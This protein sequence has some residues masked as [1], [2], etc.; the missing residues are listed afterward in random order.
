MRFLILSSLILAAGWTAWG[1]GAEITGRVT[2]PSGSV[3]PAAAVTV[4]NVAT[5]V[6]YPAKT[7][8][9]GYYSVPNLAP[10]NYQVDVKAAGFKPVVRAGIALQV[11]QVARVDFT[12]QLG[13]VSEQVE[14]SGAAPLVESET[15]DVGQVINNKSIVEMP[16]DGRNAWDLSK[17]TGAATYVGN[18]GDANEIPWVSLAGSRVKSQE[19]FLDGG[20]VQKS[21]LATAQAEL[22]PM[23]DAVE[24]FKVVTNNYAA[25]YGR[26]AAGIFVAVTKSGTNQFSGDAFEFLRNNALDARNFFALANPPLH[27]NQFGGTLGGPIRKNKTFFFVALETTLTGTGQPEILTLPTAAEKAG[28]FSGLR[29]A[30]GQMIPIYNPLTTAVNSTNPSQSTRDPFP[31][32]VI[33]ASMFDPVSAKAQSYYP[34]PNVPGTITG[35]NNFNTNLTEQRTQYHGTVKVDHNLSEKDRIFG[36][37]V[38]QHNFIPEADVFPTAAASGVGPAT[39]TIT[40]LAQTWMGSWIHTFSPTLLND[41][42]VGGTDQYR[43]ITNS[44]IGGNWPQ[45]LGLSGVPEESFPVLT[46]AGFTGLGAAN[47]YREQTNPYWQIL[48]SVSFFHGKHSF[49][50]GYEYRHQVTTD[51]FDTAPSGKFTFPAAGTGLPSSAA[52]GSG[53]A[54]FLLGF[55]GD[56]SLTK[57]AQFIMSNWAMGGY[58]QDDWKVSPRLTLN[59]GIRY[60]IETGRH[61]QNDMQSAFNMTA[62]NPVCN[63][64]GVVTFAG[65]NGVPNSNWATDT[66]NFAPRFG[67]AWR[68][69]G[70]EKT[71]VRGGYGVFFG[72]PDDQGFNNS[73]VLGFATLANLTSAN[74]NLT[75]ALYLKNGV[76]GV[77]APTAAD[78][79]PS[80][81]VGSGVDFYQYLR[82]MPY[83]MQSNFGIQH[84]Y[85]SVLISGQ[86]LMNLGRHLT[87]DNLSLN[88]IPPALWGTSANLQSLRPFP[89]F[90]ALTMDSPNL[91]AS[92]YHAFLLWVEKQYKSG[93]Q[94]LFNYTF[95]KMMDN[96]DALSDFGGEPSY[97]DY[98]NRH[99]DKAISSL[100]LE[101]NVSMEV[102]Y[103]LPWGTGRHWL[104]TGWLGRW[105][106]GWELSTLTTIHSGPPFGVTT[107]TNNCNCFSAGAQRANIV[108]NWALPSGEQSVQ[109]WFDT[110]AFAQPAANTLGDASRSVG[111]SPGAANVDLAMMKNF[112]PKDWLRAQLR[113]EF[114]NS[115][116]HPNFHPPNTVLGSPA[117]G[118]INSIINTPAPGRVIQLGLK[119]YF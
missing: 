97:E 85:H 112:Q 106:G 115:L 30:K 29:N 54:S 57:A 13:N 104:S 63:C 81:G 67:F 70:D 102:V 32:N 109:R 119:I 9:Q 26:S 56:M 3:V 69:F 39:R 5:G 93:L 41:F 2:D 1:Q 4:L 55:T 117:F 75:P 80:F 33:P 100:D 8:D 65:V 74:N 60:D 58:F 10:G 76:P 24:E 22:E 90:T 110:A 118:T 45:Q 59:L 61:A 82:P 92:S 52:T 86:Y 7:N 96:V 53:Y 18:Q 64:P 84:E 25:E 66:H 40:N 49:K 35:A 87:A 23:V 50:M 47:P 17:L 12:L 113:G 107:L 89:Q 31:G 62:I 48:E 42:K 94:L 95:S 72:N 103:D 68:P 6:R 105:I 27:Y 38:Q 116:N 34:L 20:S 21:G 77:Q 19:F 14:V 73:A 43:S 37:Y 36:R 16:L 78:R 114:F 99:L 46:P 28:D 44:S 101:H 11:E 71:V 111:W 108:G 88:E 91:G 15:S 79:T 51:Q 83:S 98:Y